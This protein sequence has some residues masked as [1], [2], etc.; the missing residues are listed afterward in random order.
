MYRV[1]LL[2]PFAYVLYGS[3][4]TIDV[5][6]VWDYVMCV[7]DLCGTSFACMYVCVELGCFWMLL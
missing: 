7:L 6:V 2:I 3:T 4:E 1:V 5:G